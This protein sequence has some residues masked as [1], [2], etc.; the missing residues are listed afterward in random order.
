MAFSIPVPIQMDMKGDTYSNW[1]F[2]RAQ[3]ENYEIATGLDKKDAKVRVATLLTVMGKECH[4]IQRHLH[5]PEEDRAKPEKILDALEKH[6]EPSRNVIY[7]RYVFNTTQQSQHETT[8]QYVAN[9]RKLADKCEFGTLRDELIRDRL[10]LGTK[11]ASARARMLRESALTLAKAIDMCRVSEQAQI[12]HKM[13]A[14]VEQETVHVHYARDRR[15]ERRS[16]APQHTQR[17]NMGHASKD[18]RTNANPC[19][20]CGA[21]HDRMNCPA[22]GI[23]CKACGKKN[24]FA[25]V[26]K[27]SQ[28]RPQ[29]NFLGKEDGEQDDET[30]NELWFLS[31]VNAVED[32]DEKWFVNLKI[33]PYMTGPVTYDPSH[34]T[35]CQLD[36]GA[37]TNVISFRDLQ[38]ITQDGNPN[39]PAS[40]AT[41]KLYDGSRVTPTG[42]CHLKAEHD[43]QTYDLKFQVMHTSQRPLLSAKTCKRLGLLTVNEKH[44]IHHVDMQGTASSHSTTGAN[45]DVPTTTEGII[46]KYEDVFEGL[47]CLPGE[48]HLEVDPEMRPVQQLPR[49]IPIPLK[50]RVT[51]AIQS[52]EKNG[53]I[54]KVTE[55][56]Q[57]I[58][59]MV[60]IEK[61]GKLRTCIDPSALNKALKRSHY[62]MPTIEEILPDIAKAK[63]FS[64]LDAKDGYWQ[65]KLD[66][67]SSYL[68]TFWTPLGRFRWMRMP[69]G[70]KPAAEEYQRRQHEALQ[71]L[72]G[73]SVIA[74]DILLY[75]CGDTTEEALADHDINLAALLQRAREV[76]LKLNRKKLKLK[77]PSVPYMGH[78]LTTEG[79]RPDPEKV[80]AVQH[81]QTPTDVKSLQRFLGFVN[82][83]AKFLPHL[84]DVCEPLRRLTDMD[85][86]WVWLPTHDSALD[87]VKQ[88]V[89]CHPV[90]KYYNLH[91]EVTLQCDASETGLGAVLLQNGQPVAF[92]SRTLTPTEQRYAQI[93]KECLAIVFA[94][95]KFDQYLHGRDRITVHSDH[96]PLEVIFRKP[97]LTAPKRLQRM[98]LRLQ[99]YHL[100]VIYKAGK[101]LHVAD[102]LS[103]AAQPYTQHTQMQTPATIY[104]M[105]LATDGLQYVNHLTD[106][107]ISTATLES[108]R[109]ATLEDPLCCALQTH[110]VQGWPSNVQAVT[111]KLRSF[112][113]YKEELTT[114]SGLIFKGNR[115]LIPDM[116]RPEFLQKIHSGHSG[117]E[118]SLRKARETV[119]WP[120]IT[121]D[122]HTHI[123][124]CSTCNA[125][126]HKQPKETLTAHQIPSLPW[127]KLGMDLFTLQGSHYLISVDYYSDYWELDELTDTT[128]ST[129]IECC[130]HQF[131]RHGVPHTV[132]TDNGPPFSSMDFQ[133]FSKTWDFRHLTSSPYH[134]QSNGKAESAVK[135]AKTLLKKAAHAGEDKWEAILAWRNTPTEGLSSSPAQ[136]LLSRRTRTFL[137]SHASLLKP[138]VMQGVL[139]LKRAKGMVSKQHYDRHAH[140]MPPIIQGDTVRVLLRPNEPAGTWSLGICIDQL[141][142]RSYEVL[143]RDKVYRRNRRHI[144]PVTESLLPMS[145]NNPLMDDDDWDNVHMDCIADG[146]EQV[147]EATDVPGVPNPGVLGLKHTRTRSNIKPPDRYAKDYVV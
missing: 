48:L 85:V 33:T 101:D 74:D 45:T 145:S 142:D 6:F 19:G 80:A 116:L 136:R 78:L 61:P 79:L 70:I 123:G 13:I 71:G 4:L 96:K 63:V 53:I 130:K 121:R 41:I 32:G 3:W 137:P 115:V 122:V 81:M 30:T 31:C 64:V 73:V 1:T 12:Q 91:D 15:S 113:T 9:L 59:N 114:D 147:P 16:S 146:G 86:E 143:V 77:L 65:V 84:S 139:P 117:T 66:E 134:S 56:T 18:K 28:R 109:A 35:T 21:V 2:F 46:S 40:K 118:A 17:E 111:P 92:A 42:M 89:T 39:I 127:S 62:Q 100:E 105:G 97:L 29:V 82:Y 52:M 58:S 144:R 140:D 129:V 57:W 104:A 124:N 107:N 94:C 23:T 72:K 138:E 51:E 43:G 14:G 7:E 75:G 120:G 60:V 98:L 38:L 44:V 37:T 133:T 47:G 128:A 126:Q 95:D 69:F 110:I 88:L 119:F 68:T 8:E 135:I 5:M 36:T 55:P 99:R 54:K 11:D 34:A 131:S 108:I 102:F 24:H 87:T 50:S 10:V 26:C 67:E 93:E 125:L 141:S 22:F 83:L 49:R 27:Q 106:V 76:N 112:W 90:L 25:K 20:Y 132:I 103:R